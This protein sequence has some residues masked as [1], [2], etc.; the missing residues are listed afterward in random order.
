MAF[1]N[2]DPQPPIFPASAAVYAERC[3]ELSWEA[4]QRTRCIRDIS[5]GPHS[6]QK[7]DV[8]LP[9]DQALRDLPVLLFLHGGAWTNGYKE[10]VGF[11]AP[12]VVAFPA[13][14][15]AVSHRLA[16]ENKFPAPLL[17]CIDALRWIWRNIRE[18]GGDPRRIFAAGHSAG[19]HLMTLTTLRRDLY[20]SDVPDSAIQ[21]CFPISGQMNLEFRDPKPD[22]DEAR[23][24]E[25][26]FNNPAEAIQASPLHWVG[27]N[28]TPIYLACGEFDWP[29]I[30]K[31]NRQLVKALRSA[32]SETT[33]KI[34]RGRDHFDMHLDLAEPN[35]RWIKLIRSVMLRSPN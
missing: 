7:L 2:L 15:V 22:S 25:V 13:I 8:Y 10:W 34:F 24:L 21:A 5:Y 18:L 9:D 26:L 28:T 31:S 11:N 1:E 27:D 14:F 30:V 3:L 16:P 20:P 32:G 4:V 19:A 29:R 12:P 6:R 17:D 35:H 23:I 33:L